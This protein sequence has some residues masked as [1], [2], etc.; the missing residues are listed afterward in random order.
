MV[1]IPLRQLPDVRVQRQRQVDGSAPVL[2]NRLRLL[3]CDSVF[4][5]R[6]AYLHRCCVGFLHRFRGSV[7]AVLL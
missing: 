6:A 2:V 4:R 7:Q 1:R 5:Y 3:S